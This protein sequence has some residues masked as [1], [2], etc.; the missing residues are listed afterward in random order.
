ME[1]AVVVSS[2]VTAAVSK[3]RV[4]SKVAVGVLD[5][6]LAAGDGVASLV[7]SAVP[8]SKGIRVRVSKLV[9]DESGRSSRCDRD[10]GARDDIGR[11]RGDNVFSGGAATVESHGAESDR[12]IV[13]IINHDRHQL[14]GIDASKS[15][16][17]KAV[18]LLGT[19]KSPPELSVGL[20]YI[21]E[22]I[23]IAACA[24]LELNRERGSCSSL[25][26]QTNTPIL[27]GGTDAVKV[28]VKV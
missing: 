1:V 10:G 2:H 24:V 16:E 27:V 20:V 25:D 12:L 17:R 28:G 18:E 26:T 5:G 9:H 4:V 23:G 15:R 6:E 3:L 13:I 21:L 8:E 22:V 14:A 19:I 11:R 7:V